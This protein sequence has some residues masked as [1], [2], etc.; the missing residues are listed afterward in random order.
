M[1]VVLA[2]IFFVIAALY[3]AVGLGGGSSYLAVMGI[4]GLPPEVIR[5]TS[6]AL[7]ILVASIGT[8]KHV[9]AGQFSARIFWPVVAASIPFAFL[10][11]R[12][13]LPTELYRPVVGIVLLYAALRLWQSARGGQQITNPAKRLPVWLALIAGAV[14][15]LV[16]GLVGIGGGIFLGP[17]LLLA[18]WADTREAMGITAAFV[19]V[20]SVAGLVG[21]YSVVP[22]LP[23]SL[24]I[25]LIVVGVGGWI[26]AEFGSNRLNPFILRRLLA[27]ILLAGGLRLLVG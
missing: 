20:N 14:I 24:I 17:L 6:L 9:R 18:G 13:S 5:P 16:S 15:G 27:L 25:W 12:L 7:N 8:W 1:D 10:G 22:E 3:G 2:I 4:M 23:P 26:G 11:G 19:V 21:R